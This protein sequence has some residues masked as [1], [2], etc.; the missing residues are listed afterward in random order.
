M[1]DSICSTCGKALAPS[2]VLYTSEA[3]IICAACAGKA[4]I[5]GDERN[6]ARNIKLAAF[7]CLGAALAGF[8]AFMV[9]FGLGFWTGAII[10]LAAGFYAGNSMLSD[11]GRF[12]KYL[13]PTEKTAVWISTIAGLVIAAYETLAI[14]GIVRFHFYLR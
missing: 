4:E 12:T 6:A 7:S 2:D 10:S 13:S 14:F 1:S 3:A 8:A 5:V 11:G 9:A